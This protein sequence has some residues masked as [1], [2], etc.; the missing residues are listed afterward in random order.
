M[1]EVELVSL[2][3]PGLEGIDSVEDLIVYVAR[4]SNPDNQMNFD[5]GPKLIKYLVDNKHWS[6][7]EMCNMVLSI[8]APRDITRQILRHRSFHFQE[9]S[10]RYAKSE[11][12]GIVRE[13]R[14]QD[15]KNRQNS[16][17]L[18]E[19]SDVIQLWGHLSNK[20][21]ELSYRAYM[22]ALDAGI[23]K[24]VARTLLP[25]GH[26]MSHMYMNGTI[27]DWIHYIGVRTHVST[28][29]EHRIVA[30]KVYKILCQQLP[31]LYGILEN[32]NYLEY[33]ELTLEGVI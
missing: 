24:E 4:V 14:L 23:A 33:L 19:G 17:E 30:H 29:K 22:E 31:V 27:R 10:Q 2:S 25:E 15:D 11:H 13:C 12:S 8:R 28:Q 32:S 1:I 18:E 16:I 20:V 5:T 3:A 26:N 9:F 7:F 21:V 6:P